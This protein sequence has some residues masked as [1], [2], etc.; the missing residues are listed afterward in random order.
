MFFAHLMLRTRREGWI[1]EE[2]VRVGYNIKI[3]CRKSK[4]GQPFGECMLP[5]RF[6]GEIDLLS[7]L[8]DRAI[9]GGLIK[10]AGPWY[11]VEMIDEQVLGRNTV[12]NMLREDEKLQKRL[13][14]ALGE[15]KL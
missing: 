7:L 10:Q 11:M 15:V 1:V 4:V 14:G 12:I 3:V 2:G 8:V 6:R 13:Q 9:E 5:F